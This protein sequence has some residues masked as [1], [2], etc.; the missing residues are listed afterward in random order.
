[1][2]TPIDVVHFKFQIRRKRAILLFVGSSILILPTFYLIYKHA[3]SALLSFADDLQNKDDRSA[4]VKEIYS[5]NEKVNRESP[6][7]DYGESLWNQKKRGYEIPLNQDVPLSHDNHS[8]YY[9]HADGTLGLD[10]HCGTCA[11][12]PSSGRLIGT[13]VGAEIDRNDCVIRMNVAPVKTFEEDYGYKTTIRVLCFMSAP[14]MIKDDVMTG[15]SAPE[16]MIFWGVHPLKQ[17]R[18]YRITL[19]AMKTYPDI[20][21]YF[22]RPETEGWAGELFESETGVTRLGSNSWLSTG[23]FAMIMAFDI[24]DEIN[25]YGMI[26][27][28]YCGQHPNDTAPFHYYGIYLNKTECGYYEKSEK[29]LKG[30]HRFIT[31]KAVFGKWATEHNVNFYYPS[32]DDYRFNKTMDTPFV[33]RDRSGF[34]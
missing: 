19:E 23:W 16:R 2:T 26:H 13:G 7:K 27:D 4:Y 30:G 18:A 6:D 3:N 5:K 32:W 17:P 31:E 12:I 24:C 28:D 21:Y 11:Y 34:T 10:F 14:G 9:M 33:M 22:F 15:R 1:M 25:V 20:K 29:M 8:T